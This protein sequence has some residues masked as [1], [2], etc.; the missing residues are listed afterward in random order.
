MASS[1]ELTLPEVQAIMRHASIQTT[2][3][4]LAVRVEEIFDK[5][6]Q[7][8]NLPQ[9]RHALPGRLRRRRHHRRVR[10]WRCPVNEITARRTTGVS[11]RHGPVVEELGFASR[12]H[13]PETRTEPAV[14]PRRHGRTAT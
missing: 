2:S 13:G 8:Y 1:R 6:T 4:Y 9:A 3:R 11:R 12:Y 5:L 7:H 10:R 14:A